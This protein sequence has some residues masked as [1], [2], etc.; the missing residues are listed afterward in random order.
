MCSSDLEDF[1][2]GASYRA[3]PDDEMQAFLDRTKNKE[4]T[5][6]DKYDYPYVHASSIQIKNEEG[7]EYDLDSLRKEIM[8]RPASI[9]GQ[10]AKMQHSETGTEA[11]FDIGL[12]ALKGL[13]VNE[14][15]GQFVVVD[16]CPGAGACKIGRAHV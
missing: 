13:A 3:V 8:T 15:T 4:K 1:G 9:L 12:P 14:K 7:R 5:K 16:T 11:I 2:L 10:N 6:R